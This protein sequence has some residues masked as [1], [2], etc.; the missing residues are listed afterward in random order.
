[1]LAMSL[2]KLGLKFPARDLVFYF[3]FGVFAKAGG[4]AFRRTRL[5]QKRQNVSL[6]KR[7]GG[8]KWITK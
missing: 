3:V 6:E 7:S 1:M 2:D 5:F 4:P 8:T